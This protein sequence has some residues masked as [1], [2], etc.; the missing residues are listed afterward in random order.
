MMPDLGAYTVTV[1]SA[2]GVSL[3]LLVALAGWY[4][5][6]GRAVRRQLEDVEARKGKHG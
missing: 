1:V 6:R 4:W 3:A 5:L 2:Y